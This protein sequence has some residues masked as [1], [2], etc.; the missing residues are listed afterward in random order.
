MRKILPALLIVPALLLTGCSSNTERQFTTE[1]GVASNTTSTPVASGS[2]TAPSGEKLTPPDSPLG[3]SSVK[4]GEVNK[5][6][7]FAPPTIDVNQVTAPGGTTDAEVKMFNDF[8]SV[9]TNSFN[10]MNQTGLIQRQN[11]EGKSY[12]YV[13]AKIGE[14]LKP[15]VK[16]SWVAT[17][18]LLQTLNVFAPVI[19][20]TSLSTQ[21]GKYSLSGN[22]YTVVT[23]KGVYKF[24]VTDGLITGMEKSSTDTLK[25]ATETSTVEY[26]TN[27]ESLSIANSAVLPEF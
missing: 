12:T 8:K 14:N 5:D 10:K 17:P 27:S 22:V 7:S 3:D 23:S 24:T 21:N 1:G 15:A 4:I 18:E 6:G 13:V 2:P 20:E 11:I 26:A 16:Y 19:A 9:I 25:I